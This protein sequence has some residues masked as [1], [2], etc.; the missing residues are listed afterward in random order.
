MA[1]ESFLTF[2]VNYKQYPEIWA[3]DEKD[4]FMRPEGGE[5]VDDVASRLSSAMATMESEYQG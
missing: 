2:V 5:S 1:L 4:P 3:M